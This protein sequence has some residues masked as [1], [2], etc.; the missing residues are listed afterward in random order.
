MKGS[1]Y[2]WTWGPDPL[3]NTVLCFP[4]WLLLT[5][6]RY[7]DTSQLAPSAAQCCLPCPDSKIQAFTQVENTDKP[8]EWWLVPAPRAILI[9]IFSLIRIHNITGLRKKSWVPAATLP[10]SRWRT[11]DKWL[12]SQNSSSVRWGV[13]KQQ[14]LNS[15]GMMENHGPGS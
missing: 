12:I 10:F 9:F 5:T 6:H 14:F 7:E 4:K 3:D 15:L 11:S 2:Q 13:W 1:N 8:G